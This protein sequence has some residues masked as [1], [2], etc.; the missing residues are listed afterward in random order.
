MKKL[1][2]FSFAGLLFASCNNPGTATNSTTKDSTTPPAMNYPYTIKQPDN[3][4]IGSPQNTMTLLSSLKAYENGNVDE[5]LK[6]WADS[7]H[8]Q[9]D[10]MDTT[11]S[12]DSIKPMFIKDRANIKSMNIKMDDWESVIS[13]DKSE[14]W[15]TLWYRQTW[16]DMDGKKDSADIIDDAMFKNGKIARLDEYTRRLHH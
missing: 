6:D 3:W 15:V 13:K 1:I 5:A 9:F 12:K 7:V 16:E 10:A 4:N 14:E 8:L 11:M 2:F